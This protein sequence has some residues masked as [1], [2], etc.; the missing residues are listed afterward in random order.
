VA[1]ALNYRVLVF[2]DLVSFVANGAETG[3][4]EGNGPGG[5]ANPRL[6]ELRSMMRS[7][8]QA[9]EENRIDDA[10][11]TFAD[12]L[13][14]TDGEAPPPDFVAGDAA[15]DLAAQIESLRDRLGCAVD[16]GI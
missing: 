4:L 13:R 16:H 6:D 2:T 7:G 3:T 11:D 12:A 15:S 5:S 10:C 14:R 8:Y 9:L 1:D